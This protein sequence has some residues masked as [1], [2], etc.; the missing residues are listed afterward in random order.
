MGSCRSLKSHPA[1]E[2]RLARLFFPLRDA[3]SAWGLGFQLGLGTGCLRE[4]LSASETL[5]CALIW[6]SVSGWETESA[7]SFCVLAKLWAMGWASL[8]SL[9]FSD[10]CVS[11]LA[12]VSAR[13]SFGSLCLTTL[14]QRL[15][16]QLRRIT[17]RK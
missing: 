4:W 9:S 15:Q 1:K 17:E 10:A 14:R 16:H 11:E 8:S 7:K 12:L 5:V 6:S 3:A 2:A 13:K